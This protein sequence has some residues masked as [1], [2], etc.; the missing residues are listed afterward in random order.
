MLTVL[1]LVARR[2]L[3]LIPLVLGITL[4]VFVIMQFSPIDPALSVLGDQATPAQ[5]EAFRAA[6]GLNDPLP[7]RYLHFLG[8][9]VRGDL[10]M[11]FPPSVPVAEKIATGAAADHPAHRARRRRRARHRAGPR[12]PG[13]PVP[14][15][16]A[17]PGHPDRL[18]GRHRH[19]VVLA[20]PAVHPGVLGPPPDLPDRRIRQPR[21]L[22]RALAAVPR[23]ARA[24]ARRPGRL[25][26][27]PHRPHVDGRGTR[28]GLRAHRRS[29]PGCR[30]AW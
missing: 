23:P 9:L 14:R 22:G 16:L 27:G 2:F 8:D 1:N 24:G 17:R 11:T 26:A 13:R 3:T 15:P 6:N 12:H 20:G 18:H 30:P 28:Q 10:G 21:R 7:L 19:A 25:L 4:F 29:A 5:V